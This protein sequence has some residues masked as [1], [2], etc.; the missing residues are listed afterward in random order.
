MASTIKIKRSASAGNA[1]NNTNI[2]TAELALNTAD[3][4]MYSSDGTDVFEIGANLTSL[5]VSGQVT[6]TNIISAN[7]S[8]GTAGQALLTDGSS[9]VYWGAVSGGGAALRSGYIYTANE[10]QTTFTG[11][12]DDT[13]TLAINSSYFDVYING[14]KISET[15]NFTSNTTA[16]VFTEGVSNN[17]IV[18]VTVYD[19][20]ALTSV[21]DQGVSTAITISNTNNIGIGTTTPA[22]TLDVNGSVDLDSL[23]IGTTQVTATAAELN[24]LDG[25]TGTLVTEAGTQTLTNKTLTAP[26]IASGGYIADAN[27]NEQIV[28]T[29]TASA[30]NYFTVT[31]TSTG[32]N[33]INL[34]GAAGSD[35]NIGIGLSTKGTGNVQIG[36]GISAGANPSRKL[37]VLTDSASKAAIG[38][39][40]SGTTATEKALIDFFAS[41]GTQLTSIGQ[42]AATSELFRLDSVSG[43]IFA[44]GSGGHAGGTER[45]RID[46]SGNV[47]IGT[48]SVATNLHVYENTNNGTINNIALLDAG[49]QNPSVAGSGVAMDFR[50][51]SGSSYFGAVGGYSDGTNYVA[52]L[53]GGAA[54]SGA[55]DLVVDSSGNVGIGTSSPAT[56]TNGLAVAGS[57]N[58]GD[59]AVINNT[60]GAWSFKKVRSDNSNAMGIYDPTGFGVMALYTAGAER[61]R[62]D[63]SGNVG[64]GTTA[65]DSAV[66]VYKSAD[67]LDGISIRQNSAGASAGAR[68]KL[69]NNS[70]ARDA[71]IVLTGSGNSSYAGAR[72]LN[73]VSNIGGFGFYRGYTTPTAT[74]VLDSSGNVGIGT[75]SPAQALDVVTASSNAYIRVARNALAAGQ[76]GLQI[77]GGTGGVDWYLFQNTGSNDLTVFG[78][79]SERMRI[80][81][82]GRLNVGGTT[83]AGRLN[84]IASNWPENA[85]A[86]YS[87]NVAGQ[88]NFAGIAFFNQDTDAAVGNVADIYTNPTGTLS[89]TSAANP[90]IQLKYGSAGIS[91][92]TPALTVDSSG[93]VGIGD[94]TPSYKLDVTGD[95]NFTGTLYQNG[96]A[97]GGGATDIDGLSDALTNSSGATIGIGTGALAADDGSNNNNTALGFQALYSNTTGYSNHAFGY[98]AGESITTGHSN[99]L[100]GFL[101]GEKLT[102][103]Y[104]NTFLGMVAGRYNT[105]GYNNVAIGNDAMEGT[106][107]TTTGDNN[108]AI[109]SGTFKSIT[110][111]YQNIA[112]GNDSGY[113]ITTG[114]RN[115]AL[116]GTGSLYSQT[117]ASD[118]TAIGS[119]AGY[120]I[121]TGIGN[122][123]VGSNAGAAAGPTTTNYNTFV[124]YY[125]GRFTPGPNNTLIGYKA[126]YGVSGS[127]TA[128]AEYMVAV[129]EHALTGITTG[130]ENTAV[131]GYAG[132]STTSGYRNTYLGYTAGDAL[133]T[134]SNNTILGHGADASSATVSN[135]ITL[136]NASIATL[137]CQVTSI[138]A[139]SDR[140]DKKNIVPLELGLDFINSLNP[141]KFTW[142]TR[143]GAKVGQ[144]EA[145]F[146]AQELDEAQ[147]AAGAETYLDIVLK[148]NLDKLEA[149]PGK[150][151]PVLVKAIQDLSAEVATLKEKINGR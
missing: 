93:N 56:F 3:R 51:N 145:G 113:S 65:P 89:L 149:A 112:I 35:T 72:T 39:Q 64:I 66:T 107:G 102:I 114:N 125:A 52:G 140:R 9:K 146:I 29:T 73:F 105:E 128:A 77:N 58:D 8:V 16:V 79:G 134:G 137:R 85:L 4:I 87:A 142:N 115:V 109:G 99:V 70:D 15:G 62:I 95:I 53:W 139:L 91:G 144:Q 141:V 1:P 12:D 20:S 19:T 138:T 23:Y 110:T 143:D 92:G 88:S 106:L 133:T 68:L 21:D 24:L 80:D 59:V 97:F 28:F 60:V 71:E 132:S 84:A 122:T 10:G 100:M 34:L 98:K 27:G 47:G 118:N 26:K 131:G 124:G 148:E 38:V 120:R 111:G 18:S 44:T 103:G 50:S 31:N 121:T 130:V 11:A 135:E 42:G 63:S 6:L 37:Q 117:T 86:V 25:V 136:G 129:G 54:A 14:I 32:A 74:M 104:G 150:L 147:I 69:G 22:Y 108:V 36:S 7:G 46:S 76:A 81:S 13:N 67:A 48:S 126:G 90:A 75:A 43:Y 55:P 40:A 83:G 17:D 45:M 123:M 82:G 57:G 2:D 94:A 119:S 101:S 41:N 116:G 61:M 30:V 33:Q 49:N 151:I 96:S 127:T 78:N 5:A